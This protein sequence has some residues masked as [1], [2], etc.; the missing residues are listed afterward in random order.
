MD[1]IP[2]L[3]S[4]A[5][6]RISSIRPSILVI[7]LRLETRQGDPHVDYL[8]EL[9][10]DPYFAVH[11]CSRTAGFSPTKEKLLTKKALDYARSSQ[12]NQLPC[13]LIKDSTLVGLTTTELKNRLTLA[14]SVSVADLCFL[15]TSND[16]CPQQTI[17]FTDQR[18]HIKTTIQP[19]STQAVVYR[20]KAQQLVY[21]K[22]VAKPQVTVGQVINKLIT[23]RLLT[24]VTFEP[25]LIAYD[26]SLALHSSDYTKSNLCEPMIDGL[27][28]EDE[29]YSLWW[30]A[31]FLVI[32]GLFAWWF[33]SG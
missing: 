20:P 1:S 3:T 10:N 32:L 28:F 24:A 23:D 13:L 8:K 33:F 9:F 6:S 25:A 22:L 18:G 19:T 31:L 30:W 27:V 17:L 16:K 12:F 5:D 21:N 15:M 4:T 26:H 7:I 2:G 11:I 29:G 14:L